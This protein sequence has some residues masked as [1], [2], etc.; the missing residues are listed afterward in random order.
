MPPC[1]PMP[2]DGDAQM[3]DTDTTSGPRKPRRSKKSKLSDFPGLMGE[4]ASAAI[5]RFLATVLAEGAYEIPDTFRDW[6]L[7]AYKNT[8]DLEAAE[9]EYEAP[10]KALLST[11]VGRASWVRG[12]IKDRIRAIVQYGFGFH[13]PAANRKDAKHNRRLAKKLGPTDLKP[14]TDQYEHPQF[15]RAIGA[16][17]FWDSNSIGVIF[18]T[19]FNPIPV[20]AVALVLTMMQAC[21]AEW[22]LGHY[23][24]QQLDIEKQQANYESHLLG[25]YE[26]EKTTKQRLTRFR[27]QWFMAGMEYS[28][29]A[30]D[31]E[32]LDIIRPYTLASNVRPDTPPLESDHDQDD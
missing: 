4:V 26:Y 8:W 1:A 17:L 6:A 9:H 12:Q 29:T 13:N 32:N 30:L 31:E 18:R 23:K 22:T 7:D 15:I 20:P 5:P 24:P 3:P 10:P 27:G 11:M 25:L 2:N 14:D 19:Q 28:G 16:G 21:I